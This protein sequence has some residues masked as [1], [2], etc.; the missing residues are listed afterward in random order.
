M[1][2]TTAAAELHNPWHIV[3]PN[4]KR[5]ASALLYLLWK[6]NLP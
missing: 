5:R 2:A 1:A 3:M 6:E 4:F